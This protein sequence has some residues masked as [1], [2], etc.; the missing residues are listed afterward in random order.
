MS[1]SQYA[2]AKSH[3]FFK[4]N[5]LKKSESDNIPRGIPTTFGGASSLGVSLVTIIISLLYNLGGSFGL[6]KTKPEKSEK[7]LLV[8]GGA[9]STGQIAIQFGKLIG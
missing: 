8:W 9:S 7:Y 3:L 6:N 1:S 4:L 5:S 2:A